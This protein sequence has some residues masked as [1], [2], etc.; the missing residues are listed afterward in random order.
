[1]TSENHHPLQSPNHALA[2]LV[3][4]SLLLIASPLTAAPQKSP[5]NTLLILDGSGSMWGK[6]KDGHKVIIAR[7]ALAISLAAHDKK[8][9]LGLMAYGH[10]RRAACN[11]IELLKQPSLLNRDQFTKLIKKVKPVGK[12]PITAALQKAMPLLGKTGPNRNIILLTD[13]P[14]NCRRDPCALVKDAKA[15]NIAIHVIAFAMQPKDAKTLHC[16]AKQT[17]GQFLTP[18]NKQKLITALKTA[19]NA[20]TN[21]LRGSIKPELSQN[22]T[23]PPGLKLSAHLGATTKALQNGL[24]WT[25]TPINNKATPEPSFES[26]KP[27]PFFPLTAG[28]YRITTQYKGFKSQKQLTLT[29]GEHKTEKLILNLGEI[30]VPA[31]WGQANSRSGFGKLVLEP[32]N[33]EAPA[34]LITLTTT[35]ESKLLPAGP[36]KVSAVENGRL[37]SWLIQAEAGK[38]TK[39]P[40]WKNTGRLKLH[41]TDATTNTPLDRPLLHLTK[42]QTTSDAKDIKL[43][44]AHSPQFDLEA[45]TYNITIKDGHAQKVVKTEITKGKT[46]ELSLSLARAHLTLK[47]SPPPNGA[48]PAITVHQLRD[49]TMHHLTTTSDLNAPLILSPGTYRLTL[50][51]EQKQANTSKTIKLKAGDKKNLTFKNQTTP[52]QLHISNRTDPLSRHQTFW[53]IFTKKDHLIWQSTEAKPNLN[54]PPGRYTIRAEIG[55]DQYALNVRL[56]G[57]KT[58]TIDLA[59]HRLKK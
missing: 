37:H 40:V 54:L 20:S 51:T 47:M 24:S 27:T 42:Q 5:S 25:I 13:G 1:M 49:K 15:N 55:Q 45:G 9:N 3:F 22:K 57:T 21:N 32:Q 2:W 10:R 58:T 18:N 26:Q 14:E 56:S 39:L 52:L 8:L 36:Y 12:T 33:N 16:L 4:I 11:D 19:L 29:K 35:Q 31:A 59:K 30:Q 17:G 38:T 41:L 28:Q 53:Q 34:N 7:Q 23:L 44:T 46:T 6:I 48:P 50:I 43:S